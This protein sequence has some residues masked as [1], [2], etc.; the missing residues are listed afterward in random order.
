MSLPEQ[1]GP[2]DLFH[3]PFQTLPER[4]WPPHLCR[5]LLSRPAARRRVIC[6]RIVWRRD[7]HTA[8]VTASMSKSPLILYSIR[9]KKPNPGF[10]HMIGIFFFGDGGSTLGPLWRQLHIDVCAGYAVRRRPW[11]AWT[12]GASCRATKGSVS[13]ITSLWYS[14]ITRLFSRTRVLLPSSHVTIS[15]F[16]FTLS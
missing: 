5:R 14:P 3:F 8:S 16:R 1:S 4:R 13:I 11:P 15:R 10:K 6:K 7:G 2:S 12:R 9:L